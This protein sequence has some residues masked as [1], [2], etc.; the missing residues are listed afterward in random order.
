MRRRW[1]LL[2]LVLAL[3]AGIAD[4]QE[5]PADP[6]EGKT[7]RSVEKLPGGDRPDGKVTL[8]HWEVRFK[9]KSFMWHHYDKIATGTYSLDAKTGTVTVKGGPDASFDATTGVLTW[10]ERKYA[11]VK[12]AK[13][14]PGAR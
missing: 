7:F 13:K 6:L 10:R 4:A 2:G 1:T 14:G 3:G 9:D 11:P 12:D 8:I 5:P